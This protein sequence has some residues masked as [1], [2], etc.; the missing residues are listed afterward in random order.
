LDASISDNQLQPY[1]LQSIAWSGDDKDNDGNGNDLNPTILS[2]GWQSDF[3]LYS[4]QSE[5][6]S[7]Q[8]ISEL[9]EDDARDLLLEMVSST[10][11][12]KPTVPAENNLSFTSVVQ[13]P[14]E[15]LLIP[16]YLYHQTYAPEPSLAVASQR[17]G[18][19]LD[20]SRVVKHI[21]DLQPQTNI[22]KPV[23]RE[24]ER[25]LEEG[26]TSSSPEN[27]VTLLFDHLQSSKSRSLS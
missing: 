12:L 7:A 27:I 14:G 2:A 3:T 20:A 26:T 10:E 11:F 15:L 1:R 18:T 9:S 13:H 16:P 5:L 8:G 19:R 25:L 6:L 17:C 23:P 24:L 22:D 21:L 4:A